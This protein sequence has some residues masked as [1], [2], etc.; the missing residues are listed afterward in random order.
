MI[1]ESLRRPL[2][3]PKQ[4]DPVELQMGEANRPPLAGEV[5]VITGASK[6]IGRAIARRL[7]N[8]GAWVVVH[9]GHDD[10]AATQTV[11]EIE[12]SGGHAVAAQADLSSL[13]QIERFFERLDA[14]LAAWA[15][16][17]RFDILVNN[18]GTGTFTPYDR[19]TE[20]EFDRLVAVNMKGTFFFTRS[21][22]SR[23][24]DGGRIVNLSSA[25][26]RRPS[27]RATV[28]T[29][30]KA[31]L[32]AFT[33]ALAKDLGERSITANTLAPGATETAMN[34]DALRDPEA[35][36]SVA[37]VTTLGRLG[38]ASDIAGVA[39]FLASKDAAW[40]TGQYLEAS[41]GLRL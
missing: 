24:R 5:A 28:S 20:R 12:T 10:R 41:G 9:Y 11:N 37:D 22:L 8:D 33:V 18:A 40:V 1:L 30:T 14:E 27:P 39:A 3:T 36:K 34:A 16:R 4:P 25:A 15:G 23:L 19:T 35:R 6:G 38:H 7:A 26:T 31:A 13:V 21:A 17:K 2:P 29:M 32:N